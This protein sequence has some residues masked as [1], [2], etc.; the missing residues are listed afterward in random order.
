MPYSGM[1]MFCSWRAR[2]KA[3]VTFA[4]LARTAETTNSRGVFTLARYASGAQ[5][6]GERNKVLSTSLISPFFFKNVCDMRSTRAGGGLSDTKRVASFV[7][8]NF[9]VEGCRARKCST[10]RPSF[11][12]LDLMRCPRTILSP[13]SCIRSSNVNPPPCLGCFKVHPVKTR[14]DLSDIFLSVAAAYPEGVQ[15]HKLAPVVFIQAGTP[16]LALLYNQRTVSCA[17]AI[18]FRNSVRNFGVRSHAQPIVQIEQHR[19]TLRSRDQ[20]VLKFSQRMRA[21]HVP[22]IAGQQVAVGAL[23]DEYVEVVEPKVGHHF[24]QLTLAVDGPQQLG[25]H[26]FVKH[27]LLWIIQCHESLAL[28]RVH[29]FKELIA[30]YRL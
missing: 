14:V 16:S 22:L 18:V 20:Q 19:R 11:S 3:S 26:Q 25:L 4:P 28:F 29:T 24:L 17:P 23:A 30:F 9:A 8:I 12:P 7:Q 6:S 13:G 21:N 10:S 5:N 2:G 15:F 27:N 1:P